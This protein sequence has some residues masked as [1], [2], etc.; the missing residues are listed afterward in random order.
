MRQ[1]TSTAVAAG[2]A[3]AICTLIT[4][5]SAPAAATPTAPATFDVAGTMTITRVMLDGAEGDVCTGGDGYDDM[6][7]GAQ[8][9]ISDGAGKVIGLGALGPG[10]ARDTQEWAGTDQC[11]FDFTVTGIPE[12]SGP[13]YGVEV[14]RRGVVQFTRDQARSLALTLS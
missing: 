8:V 5:C 2:V 7:P 1:G 3:V 12:D 11:V 4:G 9:K 6:K 10:A 13:I 14:S